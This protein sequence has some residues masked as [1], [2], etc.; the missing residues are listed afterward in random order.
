MSGYM[1]PKL[2]VARSP[3]T[4]APNRGSSACAPRSGHDL[5]LSSGATAGEGKS[6]VMWAQ[7]HGMLALWALGRPWRAARRGWAWAA[8]FGS[9]SDLIL[10]IVCLL[11]QSRAGGGNYSS[12]NA[13]SCL[14]AEQPRSTVVLAWLYNLAWFHPRLLRNAVFKFS[15]VA[16]ILLGFMCLWLLFLDLVLEDGGSTKPV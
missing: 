2:W 8:G 3:S 13:T 14:F 5:A 16:L 9:G 4:P 15:A 11:S 7:C 12:K 1:G 6:G 10:W